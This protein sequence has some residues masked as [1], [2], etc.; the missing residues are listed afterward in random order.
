MI[1]LYL[2]SSVLVTVVIAGILSVMW[3]SHDHTQREPPHQMT[4]TAVTAKS[5]SVKKIK[6]IGRHQWKY[7]GAAPYALSFAKSCR[8]AA[9][10]IDHSSMPRAVKEHFRKVL[11]NGCSGGK[12]IW[13]TPGTMFRQMTSGPDRHH[14][15]DWVMKDVTVAVLPVIRS[16]KGRLYRNGSVAETVKGREWR[17]TYEGKTYVW[18]LFYVCG[19]QGWRVISI[20]TPVCAT[21]TFTLKHPGEIVRFAILTDRRLPASSC[22]QL[23]DGDV[24]SALP[25]PCDTCNWIGPRSVIPRRYKPLYTG[26]Y[27]ANFAKQTLR[28]PVEVKQEYVAL[29]VT[30]KG[31][32]ESYAWVIPPKEWAGKKVVR[33][34]YG[35]QQ[36]PV[37]QPKVII[38]TH[39]NKLIF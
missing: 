31:F 17:W 35:S 16:P 6:R 25:S 12:N 32:G 3:W 4:H 34:P 7:W 23:I 33:V 19:N 13:Y 8:K 2:I 18:T 29:C 1:I 39:S 14:R 9:W 21:V 38:G 30:R 27:T 22:W 15:H 28:F 37:W 11:T 20:P 36:W 10:A 26:L 5:V 24:H